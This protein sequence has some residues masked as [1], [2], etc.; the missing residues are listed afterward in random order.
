MVSSS[1]GGPAIHRL[2]PLQTSRISQSQQALHYR[3]DGQIVRIK[4][5]KT[6]PEVRRTW[7][8]AGETGQRSFGHSRVISSD[9]PVS[10]RLL[11]LERMAGHP[12]A[13]AS[14]NFERGLSIS[15]TIVSLTAPFAGSSS[16]VQRE[17]PS[18]C[19]SGRN[20]FLQ[21][22]TSLLG[23]SDSTISPVSAA[24]PSGMISRQEAPGAQVD[25]AVTPAQ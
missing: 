9:S 14:I 22:T 12:L 3:I 13:T 16:N 20:S 23:W 15:W 19:R 1:A 11:R 6:A 8:L 17:W 24:R 25:S 5:R 2:G 21:V 7:R 4:Y 18:A 10:S